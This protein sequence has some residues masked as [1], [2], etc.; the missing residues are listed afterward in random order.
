MF[1]PDYQWQSICRSLIWNVS[2]KCHVLLGPF[3]TPETQQQQERSSFK[4]HLT[5]NGQ[6]K[7]IEEWNLL[8][9]QEFLSNYICFFLKYKW[10]LG[11]RYHSICD[12]PVIYLVFLQVIIGILIVLTGLFAGFGLNFNNFVV[13]IG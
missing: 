2:S 1:C 5:V 10:N 7:K 4:L 13:N 3:M 12:I 9:Y 8:F 11:W 6:S